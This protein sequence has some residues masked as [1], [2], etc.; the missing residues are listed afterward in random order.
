MKRVINIAMVLILLCVITGCKGNAS[1]S[2]LI[3]NSDED[4]GDC[5]TVTIDGCREYGYPDDW[6]IFVE[7]VDS[8]FLEQQK[9]FMEADNNDRYYKEI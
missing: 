2:V 9:K 3:H 8:Y 7:K 4:P 5:T 6:N 1:Y